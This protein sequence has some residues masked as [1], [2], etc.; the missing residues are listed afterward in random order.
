MRNDQTNNFQYHG[1]R[2]PKTTERIQGITAGFRLQERHASPKG[3]QG[4]HPV[5]GSTTGWN[6]EINT[7]DN[8]WYCHSKGHKSGGDALILFAVKEGIIKCENAG[9]GCLNGKWEE[10]FAALERCGYK[11]S[12]SIELEAM[13]EGLIKG[14][15]DAKDVKVSPLTLSRIRRRMILKSLGVK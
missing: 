14:K 5:H 8:T 11:N 12:E 7:D 15:L 4:G 3:Y 2:T 1:T 6:Y 9:P 10:V 13:A